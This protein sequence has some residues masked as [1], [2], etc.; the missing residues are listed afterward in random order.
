MPTTRTGGLQKYPRMEGNVALADERLSVLQAPRATR[1][2]PQLRL[3]QAM[4]EEGERE[5]LA[6]AIGMMNGM[7]LSLT[8]WSL[9]GVIMLLIR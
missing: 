9:I 4:T 2:V 8:L 7:R 5:A 6:P 1:R 3:V